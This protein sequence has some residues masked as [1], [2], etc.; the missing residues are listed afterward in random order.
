MIA[1]T[2][3]KARVLVRLRESCRRKVPEKILL[4]VMLHSKQHRAFTASPVEV[5]CRLFSQAARVWQEE[6]FNQFVV[7]REVLG[8]VYRVICER[9]SQH[10]LCRLIWNLKVSGCLVGRQVPGKPDRRILR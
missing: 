9:H 4:E 3:R 1:S 10:G 2:L 5:P 7:R 8:P 6:L